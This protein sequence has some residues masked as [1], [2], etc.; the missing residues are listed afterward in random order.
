M[1]QGHI[2]YLAEQ[3]FIEIIACELNKLSP[4]FQ[5][6]LNFLYQ[7]VKNI[8][9]MTIISKDYYSK[10]AKILHH[11]YNFLTETPLKFYSFYNASDFSWKVFFYRK[12]QI[13]IF[14]H[15]IIRPN[16]KVAQW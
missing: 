14:H 11:R 6:H 9:K 2:A 3:K 1:Q 4:S 15:S 7:R 12:V 5:K 13:I 8:I 10:I 16:Y